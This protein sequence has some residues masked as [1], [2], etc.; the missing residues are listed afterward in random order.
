MNLSVSLLIHSFI[1]T[2]AIQLYI[3]LIFI[4]TIIIEVCEV[5]VQL[6]DYILYSVT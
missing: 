5:K 3:T 1:R 2:Y 4:I 6:H